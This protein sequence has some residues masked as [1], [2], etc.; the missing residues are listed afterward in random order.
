VA[1]R[2]LARGEDVKVKGVAGLKAVEEIPASHKIALRDL[3]AGEEI[4]KYGEVVAVTTRE[5]KRGEWVHTHN[6][7]SR[8]WKK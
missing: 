8:R 3:P 4:V 7:E 5:I 6:L 1:L 2:N